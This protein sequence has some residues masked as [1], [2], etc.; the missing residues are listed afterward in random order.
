[1]NIPINHRAAVN[2]ILIKLYLKQ[3]VTLLIIFN[4]SM[5]K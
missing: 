2:T 3:N 5:T 4:N 1:M